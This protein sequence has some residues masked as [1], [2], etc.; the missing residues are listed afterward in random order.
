MCSYGQSLG[1][2][3]F[4]WE[5]LSEVQFFKDYEGCSWF[6]FNNLGLALDMSLKFYTSEAKRLR[7]KFWGLTLTFAEVTGEDLLGFFW[8]PPILDRV[9]TYYQT[10]SFFWLSTKKENKISCIWILTEKEYRKRM[11][12]FKLQYIYKGVF[13]FCYVI[14]T[15]FRFHPFKWHISSV[16]YSNII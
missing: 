11:L 16:P 15:L 5:K 7:L 10:W 8:P 2:L 4:L 12:H 14:H 9:K 6:K 1:T 13:Y 3:T